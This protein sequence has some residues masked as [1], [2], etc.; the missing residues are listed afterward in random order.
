MTTQ[1]PPSTPGAPQPPR[2]TQSRGRRLRDEL[3]QLLLRLHF[4]V[5]LFVGPFLLIAAITGILYACT[6]Q[7]EQVVYDKQL[8]AS[9]DDG[10]G[11]VPLSQQ[12]DAARKAVPD[13]PVLEIRPPKDPGST[14]RVSFDSPTVEAD[15]QLTAFVDPYSGE[16][17]GVLDTMGEWLPL[18]T[19]FDDLH[20][21]LHLGAPG[22]AYS[23]LAAS[24]LWVLALSGIIIWVTR[25]VRK[26]TARSLLVPTSKGPQRQ[27]SLSRHATVGIWAAIG[28][29]FL[30]ATGLTWS[31]YAGGNVSALRQSMDWSTPYLSSD[32]ATTDTVA[33]DDV[34]ATAESVL[35]VARDHGLSDP[36]AIAPSTDGG[37][38]IVSQVQRSWPLK[39]DSMAIDPAT[40][41][42]VGTTRFADWPLAGKLAEAG[43]SLHMGL[44]FGWANQLVLIAIAV[45]VIVL[46]VI[47]YRMWWRRRPRP[48]RRGLP[49]PLGRPTDSAAAYGIMIGVAAA[50]GL[51]LPVFGVSLV[52]FVLVDLV[53]RMLPGR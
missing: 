50:V 22:R 9:R 35:D 16:V 28:L 48:P 42:V 3:K 5:G 52:G 13:R 11:A 51:V 37:A 36:V 25:K 23:E 38:W 12:V 30:S 46:V 31:Q 40:D 4:Y 19:W 33:E 32:V 47:G 1:A 44:L 34:P 14:T 6:P 43:I 15:H 39:Q 26:R 49:T 8:H 45:A 29:F 53:R 10:V 21:H 27:R 7:I 20:R 24:W 18:R 2:S 41:S 17:T